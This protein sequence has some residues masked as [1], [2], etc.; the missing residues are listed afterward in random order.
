[1]KRLPLGA[2]AVPVLRQLASHGFREAEQ[3]EGLL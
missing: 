3:N 2:L 1:L